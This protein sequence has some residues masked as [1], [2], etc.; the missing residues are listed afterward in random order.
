MLRPSSAYVSGSGAHPYERRSSV[1]ADASAPPPSLQDDEPIW[2]RVV[3]VGW[4]SIPAIVAGAI[5]AGTLAM[6][7]PAS[8]A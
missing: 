2:K 4:F 8:R 3:T 7:P 1:G 5:F 6:R